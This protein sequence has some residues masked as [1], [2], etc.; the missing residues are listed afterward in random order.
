MPP[1]PVTFGRRLARRALLCA[2]AALSACALQ[3]PAASTLPTL[4]TQWSRT[5]PATGPAAPN[6]PA[7]APWWQ[8][9]QDPGLNTLVQAAEQAS[10]TL[11]RAMA[12]LDEARASAAAQDANAS[13]SLRADAKASRG[14]QQSGSGLPLSS[15]S[16]SLSLA[17][18]LDLFGGLRHD[19]AAA[20]QRL[21][22]SRADAQGT[23]LSLQAQVA[24]ATIAA[25]ACA[26][27]AATRR[28]DVRSRRAALQLTELRQA[29]GQVAALDSARSR[30]S[31]A[32]AEINRVSTEEQCAEGEQQLVLLTGLPLADVSRALGTPAASN[33]RAVPE[34]P[35]LQPALPATVLASHPAV[36]SALRS[37]DAAWE[38]IGSAEAA[39]R[40]SMSL[41]ALLGPSWLRAAGSWARSTSW[42]LAPAL[43]AT[44]WDGGRGAAHTGAARARH[45][46][47]LASLESTLRSAVQDGENALA[48]AE[49]AAERERLAQGG[50]AAAAQLLSASLASHQAGRMSL[51]ELE[52]ARRSFNN[53]Q[54]ALITAQ[55]DRAR[56]WVALVKAT[57]AQAATPHDTQGPT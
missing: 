48:L 10:P 42:S 34:P 27:Q 25:R 46:Q 40:P 32:D 44:L 43:G 53:A 50:S 24:D 20:Q 21:Q 22:A 11:A 37:A 52:D 19:R 45:A 23:R 36:V 35:P 49:G 4:P 30:S 39:R 3:P 12:R 28:E 54:L 9:L 2:A 5:S 15:A 6:A 55:R 1:N 17:W 56:A 16:A 18:E 7:S 51:F 26:A 8:A 13:P 14:T 38:Y 31:L 41:S 33:G 47:A 57:G 29:A